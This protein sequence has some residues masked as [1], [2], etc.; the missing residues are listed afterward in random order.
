MK[1][2][3]KRIVETKIEI[4]N[5][6]IYENKIYVEV[7]SVTLIF[8]LM[9]FFGTNIGINLFEDSLSIQSLVIT[10]T[11]LLVIF[12]IYFIVNILFIT[13]KKKP[14]L[15]NIKKIFNRDFLEK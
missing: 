13:F 6:D 5:H 12:L 9:F 8:L 14:V 1:Q 3:E 7:I 11:L 4:L 15:G 2:I 10:I